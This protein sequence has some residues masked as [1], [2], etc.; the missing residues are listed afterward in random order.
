[1]PQA[2]RTDL[3]FETPVLTTAG[4]PSE[5]QMDDLVAEVV[6]KWAAI[7][8]PSGKTVGT[9][10]V[11][12]WLRGW[13]DE[14]RQAESNEFLDD[15]FLEA[16]ENAN[17]GNDA[18]LFDWFCDWRASAIDALVEAGRAELIS[19]ALIRRGL[20]WVLQSYSEELSVSE[21][22]ECVRTLSETIGLTKSGMVPDND[23]LLEYR[24][25]LEWARD[26]IAHGSDEEGVG[27]RAYRS[28][29]VAIV[30][31]QIGLLDQSAPTADRRIL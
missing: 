22:S 28:M 8:A 9:E 24:R 4:T 20:E 23:K 3:E 10:F 1:M 26:S 2:L 17:S 31:E 6:N 30:D 15:I 16:L 21:R 11:L 19:A 5:R 12:P 18:V 29:I 7:D 14:A 13:I 25:V 27:G